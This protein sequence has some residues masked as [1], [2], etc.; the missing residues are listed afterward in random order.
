[1]VI[2]SVWYAKGVFGKLWMN[3][4][5]LDE[6]EMEKNASKTMPRAIT[7]ALIMSFLAAFIIAHVAALSK[8]FY[9]IG[10]LEAG[11]TTAFWLWAG[12]SVTTVVV[13]DVFEGRPGKLTLLTIGNQF[14][15]LLTMGL[16]IGLF[17]GF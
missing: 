16:I 5:K 2:G 12:I 1:M 15:T 6:K 11:L 10:T 13:H 9:D 14:F 7:L 4:A 8:A 3:L 17:G